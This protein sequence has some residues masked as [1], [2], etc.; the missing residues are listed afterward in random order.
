[1]CVCTWLCACM[2]KCMYACVRVHPEMQKSAL[3][4][5]PFCAEVI[6]TNLIS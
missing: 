2:C 3:L 4:Q 5:L 6:N 1:M